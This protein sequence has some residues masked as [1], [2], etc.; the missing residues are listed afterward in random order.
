MTVVFTIKYISKNHHWC[1]STFVLYGVQLKKQVK[2]CGLF[3]IITAQPVE[4]ATFISLVG[5]N[6]FL[7]QLKSI[8]TT[9]THCVMTMFSF[10]CVQK[11]KIEFLKS[12]LVHCFKVL[13]ENNSVNSVSFCI[14]KVPL[15]HGMVK[16]R[17]FTN[18]LLRFKL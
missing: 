18:L 1:C 6:I 4:D 17:R 16:N 15:N 8:P 10:V 2:S 11:N 13:C 3:K 5:L 12:N 7:V 9:R 14:E